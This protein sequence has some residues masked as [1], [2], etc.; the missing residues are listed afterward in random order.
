MW[1]KI[2]HVFAGKP[3]DAEVQIEV[4]LK[5]LKLA[6]KGHMYFSAEEHVN[7]AMRTLVK[8]RS[9]LRRNKNRQAP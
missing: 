9:I 2:K 4:A 5:A 6:L 7:K 8:A 1:Q 3:T